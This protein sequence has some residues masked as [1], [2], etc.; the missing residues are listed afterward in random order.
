MIDVAGRKVLV[1]G[2]RVAGAAAAKILL[3]LGADVSIAD[4][5]WQSDIAE[6]EAA[7]AH[8]VASPGEPPPG[9]DLIVTSPGWRMDHPLF[10]SARARGIEIIGEIELAWRL[11]GPN[12]APWLAI[13]GTN[14]KTTTVRMLESM[15]RAAGHRALAVGNVGVPVVEA[16]VSGAYDV[17][18]VELSSYQLAWSASVRPT[19]AAVLNLAPD[20]LDWHGSMEAYSAAKASI[21]SGEVAIGNADDASVATLLERVVGP[22]RVSFTLGVPS[23][24]QLGV[25]D[26]Q[27]V[28]RAF[29]AGA[30]IGVAEI[31]PAGAHNV[32]NALAAAALALAA[33][34]SGSQIADGLSAFVPD[35]HRNAF[36]ATVG[37]VDFV[38]DSKATNPH[39]ATAALSGYHD[40]VWIAGGQLK[41]VDVDG[42]VADVS[43]RAGLLVGV[44]LLGVDRSEIAEALARHAPDIP[45]IHVARTDDEAMP[46][47]VRAAAAMARAGDTVLLSPAAASYDMFASYA[48]RGTRFALAVRALDPSVI[49]TSGPTGPG[50]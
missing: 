43:A 30:L 10:E 45:V 17:L 31:R 40:V 19:A 6:L 49:A 1:C 20:H 13:T 4:G 15:L 42:F 38:D 9:T 34:V 7:G 3:S 11:R 48:D 33:G 22:R 23:E 41:G 24:G 44:V 32:A 39:A 25:A 18:A 16:V 28:D 50:A 47:V 46:E 36:V 12:A 26:G 27:L 14:G 37:G 2:G 35:P 5:T 8:Y 29:G 21:W